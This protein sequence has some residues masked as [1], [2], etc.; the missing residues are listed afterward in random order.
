MLLPAEMLDAM[1]LRQDL[2]PQRDWALGIGSCFKIACHSPASVECAAAIDLYLVCMQDL[3]PGWLLVQCSEQ[4]AYDIGPHCCPWMTPFCNARIV[5]A[6]DPSACVTC[7]T[8]SG[9]IP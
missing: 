4:A 3:R 6:F 8:H 1:C 5:L 7:V 2:A 9:R